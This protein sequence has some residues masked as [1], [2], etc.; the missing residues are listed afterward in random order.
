M[1]CPKCGYQRL[2]E[3]SECPRCGIIY[4]KY[5]SAKTKSHNIESIPK[6][7]NR[8]ESKKLNQ[9]ILYSKMLIILILSVFTGFLLGCNGGKFI[10]GFN[11]YVFIPVGGVLF[12]LLIGCI[13]F[14]SCY[15]TSLRIDSKMILALMIFSSV[16]YFAIDYGNYFSMIIP[17]SGMENIPD[18]DYRIY[19]IIPFSE[20]M[21]Y[22]LSSSTISFKTGK[23][24]LNM[25]SAGTTI[26]YIFDIGGASIGS[27][28]ILYSLREKY[29]YCIK[30]FKYKKR[31]KKFQIR[32][33]HN[34]T[35]TRDLFLKI[36]DAIKRS[37]YHG[38]ISYIQKSSYNL[39]DKDGDLKIIIDHRV[40]RYCSESSIVGNIYRL[41]QKGFFIDDWELVEDLN[42]IFK[43]RPL[44]S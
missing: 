43:S 41:K 32:Y 2:P 42:S 35:F 28:I 25:G 17:V 27:A 23:T 44:N 11:I 21:K 22:V 8:L 9:K 31:A 37:D 19:K 7:A 16:G 26:S 3:S 29:P 6:M 15:L 40:C 12:G 14:L 5:D 20:Y 30:C 24:M 1:N 34:E 39:K 38:L 13:Q 36:N 10:F 18:G 33:K 4:S